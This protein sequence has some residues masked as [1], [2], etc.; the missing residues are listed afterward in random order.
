MQDASPTTAISHSD[1]R[2][3]LAVI[4]SPRSGNTWIRW[5]LASFYDLKPISIHYP[6]E[7][8][9]SNLPERCVIQIHWYPLP[10][11]LPL[12]DA[13]DIRVIQPLRHP[14]DVLLS[15]LN[16]TYFVHEDG[17]CP[18]VCDSCRIVGATPR[19]DTFL[20][21]VGSEA[22]RALLCYAPAWKKWAPSYY[23]PLRY[24]E[25]VANP[26]PP[27]AALSNWLGEPLRRPIDEVLE[28]TSIS[29]LKAS[30]NSWQYHFWQGRPG[31]WKKM[32]T[33]EDVARILKVVSDPFD[34]IGFDREA[35]PALTAEQADQNWLRL[36]LDSF[37][38]HLHLEKSKH[39]QAREEIQAL[40]RRLVAV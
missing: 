31:L 39:Q 14:L 13:N 4:G 6:H 7:L 35:D 26:E 33:R 16:Y 10:D 17:K 30:R 15:W 29:Q 27:L 22:G 19:S 23:F 9:W 18:G 32:F 24:E 21:Y 8:D 37:R 40:G 11:F 3:R 5:M 12:L 2:L 34:A 20:D 25:L 1:S 28:A 38:E 36:Q